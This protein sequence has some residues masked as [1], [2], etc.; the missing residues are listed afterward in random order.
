MKTI[1]KYLTLTGLTAVLCLFLALPANA[2]HGG[3][4]GSGSD[5]VHTTAT[6][7]TNLALDTLAKHYADQLSKDGWT[8]TDT[9]MSGPL[10]WHTWH[11]TSKEDQQPWGGLF[12]ILKTPEKPDDYFLYVRAV[13]IK[14]E[15][16]HKFT[17]WYSTISTFGTSSTVIRNINQTNRNQ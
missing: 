10:A 16:D 15:S 14:P 3:G 17:G 13:W 7:K 11:F 12:F 1:S 8:Q 9:G 5:E 2:Q 6:L 4:G